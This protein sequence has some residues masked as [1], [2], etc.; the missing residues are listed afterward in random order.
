[1]QV[2]LASHQQV[3]SHS[4]RAGGNGSEVLARHKRGWSAAQP[5]AAVVTLHAAQNFFEISFSF[6]LFEFETFNTEFYGHITLPCPFV[7]RN[8]HQKTTA[9]CNR[10]PLMGYCSS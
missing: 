2:V 3:Q 9:K 6:T 8:S 4:C 7:S 1:M 5:S 10:T